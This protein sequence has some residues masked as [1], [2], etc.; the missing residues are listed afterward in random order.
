MITPQNVSQKG[1][2]S[3]TDVLQHPVELLSAANK[4]PK[5]TSQHSSSLR[6]ALS[7]FVVETFGSLCTA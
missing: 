3:L 2:Q 6:A 1:L 7:D 5:P 4:C